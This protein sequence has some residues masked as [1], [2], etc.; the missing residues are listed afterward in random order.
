MAYD[1]M[2][3]RDGIVFFRDMSDEDLEYW[4][5]RNEDDLKDASK[6]Q[7][8][9][10]A[11]GRLAGI[12]AEQAARRNG[13]QRAAPQA[14]R[15]EPRQPA[16]PPPNRSAIQQYQGAHT[17]AVEAT[18]ALAR[19]Q[20]IGHLVSPAPAVG[21]LPEGTSLVVSAVMVDS[22]RETYSIQ[23]GEL[24]LS[25]TALQKI[26]GAL[27]IAWS[28]TESRRLDDAS[29]PCFVHYR[30]VGYVRD[31]S[32][33]LSPVKG[34]K[35]MDLR[36]GSPQLEALRERAENKAERER[37]RIATAGGDPN[38]VKTGDWRSQVRDLRL[39]ILEHAETKAQLRAIRSLGLRSSYTAEELRKPFFA[40]R[41]QFTGQ[42]TDPELRRMF[43]EKIADS[44]L[45]AQSALYGQRAPE[46]PPAQ[47]AQGAPPPPVG[48]DYDRKRTMEA[49]A[50]VVSSRPVPPHDADGVV[51][52]D[53]PVEDD[54]RPTGT[55]KY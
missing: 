14:Q 37:A 31:F 38:T 26:A 39:F 29:D 5:K 40:A 7:Y 53:E 49:E 36:E 9:K 28:G 52:D 48:E 12:R 4:L 16:A 21:T 50:H 3:T 17:D 54:R 51:E 25:R 32:G 47:Q 43:A 18:A 8:H 19:I 44:F 10:N 42:T 22:A 30:A 27:G 6:A 46:L 15:A 45:G 41:L 34:E 2:K 55:D 23:G 13:G 24:G 33:Q 11:E 35:I 1:S 20:E